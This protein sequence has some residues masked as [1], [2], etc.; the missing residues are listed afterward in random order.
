MW[1]IM[2]RIYT[3]M[4]GVLIVF[5]NGPVSKVSGSHYVAANETA[6]ITNW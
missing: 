2:Y 3:Y 5:I 4:Y 1:C 6:V